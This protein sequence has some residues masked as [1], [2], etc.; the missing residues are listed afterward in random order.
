MKKNLLFIVLLFS[1]TLLQSQIKTNFTIGSFK[2]HIVSPYSTTSFEVIIDKYENCPT[3]TLT[4]P[5]SIYWSYNYETYKIIGIS[6]DAFRDCT[7]LTNVVL[8][9]SIRHLGQNAFK[10]TGLTNITYPKGLTYDGGS[11]FG[12]CSNLTDVIIEDGA[13]S[14]G[15]RTFSGCLSLTSVSIPDSVTSIGDGVFSNCSSLESIII[16]ESVTSLGNY[17]FSGNK[18]LISVKIPNSVISMGYNVFSNCTSLTNVTISDTLASVGSSTFSDCSNLTSVTIPESVTSIGNYAFYNCTSL[19]NVDVNWQTPLVI[20]ET[21]FKDVIISNIPLT[22]PN[23]T[24]T[25]YSSALIW[26]DFGSIS[27]LNIADFDNHYEVKLFPN[28]TSSSLIIKLEN[29]ILKKVNIYNSLGQL[30]KSETSS[31]I[32]IENLKSG[33]YN[34]NIITNKG[35]RSKKFIV[36]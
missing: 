36:N 8:P 20:N 21:V 10:N 33:I 5:E 24:E 30:V 35:K 17:V 16:P 32:N 9:E 34:I 12:D 15:D 6:S 31:L 14:F 26:Q 11:A 2:Y 19:I 7:N 3:G 18:S 22:V 4:I 25:L 29:S 28:P 1:F 27:T 23:N 13:T